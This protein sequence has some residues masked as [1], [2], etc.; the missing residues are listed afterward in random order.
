M[1]LKK[2]A[3]NG[4]GRIGRCLA[5]IN[6]KYSLFDL[7]L[8]NDTNASVDSLAY[9]FQYDSTYGRL[10]G[11]FFAKNND[12]IINNKNINSDYFDEEIY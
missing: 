11:N 3:I 10:A 5:K 4:F 7:V 12:L 1:S 2:I 8:I 6:I 9:L